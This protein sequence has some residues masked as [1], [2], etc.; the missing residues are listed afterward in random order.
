[1]CWNILPTTLVKDFTALPRPGQANTSHTRN[2]INRPVPCFCPRQQSLLLTRGINQLNQTMHPCMH[3]GQRLCMHQHSRLHCLEAQ[4]Q[5][6]THKP[7]MRCSSSAAKTYCGPT[8]V[9][10][11]IPRVIP[12][13]NTLTCRN[14]PTLLPQKPQREPFSIIASRRRLGDD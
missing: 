10:T 11:L 9:Q 13:L 6:R 1:M 8:Q 7:L 14:M 2:Q 4:A 5:Q 12:A 3:P